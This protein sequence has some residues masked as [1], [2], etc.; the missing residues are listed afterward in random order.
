MNEE[1]NVSSYTDTPT[2]NVTLESF[3]ETI[4][5]LQKCPP[6]PPI[7]ANTN[8]LAL[9]GHFCTESTP[10]VDY[11]YTFE[12]D[13]LFG[14]TIEVDDTLEDYKYKIG[15]NLYDCREDNRNA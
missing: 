15:N 2:P 1:W 9:I 11:P 5:Q 10:K 7:S 12:P 13:S 14:I 4:Q 8:T 6:Q 3:M